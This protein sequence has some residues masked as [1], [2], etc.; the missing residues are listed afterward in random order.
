[1][2]GKNDGACNHLTDDAIEELNKLTDT[3][4]KKVGRKER[5][6]RQILRSMDESEAFLY[7]KI[8]EWLQ[9][10]REQIIKDIRKKILR[11]GS[12]QENHPTKIKKKSKSQIV[13]DY[14]DWEI[15]EN[16][17]KSIVKP[18]YLN[19]MEKSGNLA[20]QQGR[21]EASFDVINPQSV[22]QAEKYSYD[23][24]TNV[25]K[26][27]KA[28]LRAIVT[29]G[30][31]KGKTLVQIA[32]E[33]KATGIGLNERQAKTLLKYG[34]AL[35]AQ[36]ITGKLYQEKWK[37]YFN[38]LQRDRS[39][40]IARTE[41]SRSAN[42]GYL[43]SLEGTRYEEVELSSAADACTDCLALAGQKFKRSEAK[44]MLPIHPN[45]RCHW[46]VVIPR[47]KKPRIPIIPRVPRGPKPV[48][49]KPQTP[50]QVR[51]GIK[52]IHD[53][54]FDELS[55]L[56]LQ[57][58]RQQKKALEFRKLGLNQSAEKY[59]DASLMTKGKI[60]AIKETNA[61]KM[62]K[63]LQVSD[64]G[65]NMRPEWSDAI[66]EGEKPFLRNGVREFS[67][68]IDEKAIDVTLFPR[69]GRAAQRS[70][71]SKGTCYIGGPP[72]NFKDTKV[73]VH[74]LGH[75]L[76]EVNPKMHESIMVFY[77]KRTKGD[78]LVRLL[79]GFG[80]DE[81]TRKDKFID[82][83]MGKDYHGT[84][85]EILS[86]GLGEFYKNPYRLATSDPEYFDFIFRLVRGIY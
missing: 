71:Y 57:A 1:M 56:E 84:A 9:G 78:T 55:R 44:G 54:E 37:K 24:V 29:H 34:D 18:A 72:I 10:A 7:P 43:E 30:M 42:E 36:G 76:E 39:K 23:L 17:G 77:K 13:V 62:R 11:K 4:F 35:E 66:V 3:F 69:F 28:G 64:E 58:F 73:V 25:G 86:M 22:E 12:E 14:V 20:R 51:E 16:N 6:R 48:P 27:T 79:D 81:L 33:I 75:F 52:K 31:K 53:A 40:M 74:E 46:I 65:F 21:I 8:R 60:S 26:E 82:P 2:S 41:V 63:L 85:S 32:K 49:K 80:V 68:L 61:V 70:Y 83:Y 5:L 15:I 45:C 38:R 19:V 50:K 59:K 47:K 67:K